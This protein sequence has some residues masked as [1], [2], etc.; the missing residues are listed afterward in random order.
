MSDAFVVVLPERVIL[1]TNSHRDPDEAQA[2]AWLAAGEHLAAGTLVRTHAL[3]VSRAQGM[4]G[5]EM[6][7]NEHGVAIACV[8]RAPGA[9]A[10]T[11]AAPDLLR[12]GLER[13]AN[14]EEAVDVIAALRAA[15]ADA[16]Q[17]AFLTADCCEAWLLE[18]TGRDSRRRRIDHGV[19]ALAGALAVRAPLARS[20][21]LQDWIGAT[22]ARRNR[23]QVLAGSVADA[24]SAAAALA[25]HGGA[26]PRY[27]R[28]AGAAAA[29]CVHAGGCLAACQTTAS[30]ISELTPQGNRH[31]AT[32]T[33]APCLSL[34]RSLA[35]ARP[36]NVGCP[37]P[38]PERDS[39]WWRFERLHRH[40]L[41]DPASLPPSFHADRARTQA[42]IFADP[43]AGW[44][45]AED[46]LERWEALALR[47]CADTR[48]AWLRRHWQRPQARVAQDSNFDR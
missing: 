12:L 5:A 6:G 22:H 1:A 2:P 37:G 44:D 3:L 34:F 39:L 35:L 4:R 18:C 42:A 45:L 36:R 43:V 19:C 21:R 29:P 15:S 47:P 32:G 11:L 10:D 27:G 46:W 38:G 8:T 13:A 33:A 17:H 31:W 20:P 7:A 14:A 30:W 24:A 48:P 23:L 25:D 9:A 26:S 16:G 41:R 28:L 40:V